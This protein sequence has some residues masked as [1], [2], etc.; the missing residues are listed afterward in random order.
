MIMCC[1]DWEQQSFMGDL[2]SERLVDI[3]KG[4]RYTDYRRRFATGDIKGLIC[5]GCRKQLPV[6]NAD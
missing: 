5:H 6:K 3:W 1:T 2:A 4:A